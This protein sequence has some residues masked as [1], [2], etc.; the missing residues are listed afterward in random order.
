M[1]E[2]LRAVAGGPGGRAADVTVSGSCSP[3]LPA[4]SGRGCREKNHLLLRSCLASGQSVFL[5]TRVCVNH[6]QGAAVCAY[7]GHHRNLSP[8]LWVPGAAARLQWAP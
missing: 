3:G 6:H 2:W 4:A 7:R 1:Q 5:E 8:K